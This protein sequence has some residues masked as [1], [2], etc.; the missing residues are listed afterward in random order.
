MHVGRF[1]LRA[2]E[3]IIRS[4]SGLGYM[5]SVESVVSRLLDP[6]RCRNPDKQGHA[7]DHVSH[8]GWL[9]EALDF[10]YQYIL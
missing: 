5:S 7:D 4:G 1:R 8:L 6:S 3:G 9:D 2:V 10:Y